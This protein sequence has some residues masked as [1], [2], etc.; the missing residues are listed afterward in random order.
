MP[1][2]RILRGLALTAVWLVVAV[3]SGLT[4]F[5]NS[6]R[7]VVLA[8]HDAV[9]R[10]TLDG[11]VVLRTGPVLPD[12]RLGSGRLLGVDVNLGKTN[13][14]TTE[15]LVARYGYIASQPEGQ[16]SKVSWSLN[17][18]AIDAAVRGAI[19][20]LLPV[21]VW[22]AVGP[23]RRRE[24]VRQASVRTLVPIGLG[25]VLVV[26]L[27]WEPWASQDTTVDDERRWTTLADYLGAGIPVPDE[28]AGVEVRTDVTTFGSRRLIHSALDTY[29]KSRIFYDTA[30]RAAAGLDV[31]EPEEGETVVALV[32]DRHD[33]IGMDPVARAIADAGGAT[34][35]LDAGDDTSSGASWEAF[36]L[37]SV[38]SAFEDLDRF[39]VTG[40]H[41]HGDFAAEYLK[42]LGWTMLEGEVIDGPG[43]TK[44]LGV[45]DPRASGLGSWRDETGLSFSEVEARLADEA[46]ASEERVA[47]ILVH[48]PNL[49]DEA[50]ER[51]CADLVVGGHH[52]VPIGPERV[53]GENGEIGFS[54]TTGTTGGA[55]YAIAVGSKPRREAT[56]TL[57]TYR[58]G[59][60]AGVQTVVLQTNGIFVVQDY[61][62]LDFDAEVVPDVERPRR[63]DP[64][65]RRVG[66]R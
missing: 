59:R 50:L 32:S 13:A 17:D 36:S 39:A 60:P 63:Q 16:I 25:L 23:A 48:D 43:G 27:L 51:G 11:Y 40:N 49:A 29:E 19:A 28:A 30:A 41:D 47:T 62:P 52:H 42:S 64:V 21:V 6:D 26:V 46:C 2:G 58:D 9:L 12:L 34:A 61:E 24:L 65:E 18:M 55:A 38:T 7:T 1:R 15:E 44:L 57:L 54:Y 5:L 3:A 4:I 53:E 14:Q 22:L 33:N 35:V 37:D 31:R 20:G 10:P 45:G 66:R 56:V 8:S